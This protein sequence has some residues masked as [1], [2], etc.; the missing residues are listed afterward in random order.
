MAS[1]ITLPMMGVYS[2]TKHYLHAFTKALEI[3]TAGSGVIIQELV[4]GM[5]KTNMTK[6]LRDQATNDCP[7]ASTYV[8]SALLTLGNSQRTCGWWMHSAK[9]ILI[10]ENMTEFV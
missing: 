2:G 5:V 3:E 10:Y 4:P 9:L 7:T 1:C 8:E 6:Y